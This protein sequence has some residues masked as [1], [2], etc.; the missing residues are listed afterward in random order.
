MMLTLKNAIQSLLAKN[1][2]TALTDAFY[3]DLDFGTGGL[4]GIMGVGSNRV[5]KYTIGGATQGFSNYLL[6]TYP[7]QQVKVAIAHDSRNDSDTLARIT[8]E[9]FAANGIYVYF[10]KELRPTPM[11]SFAIRALGCQ[12]GCYADGF[13]Q[14][15]R[16]QWL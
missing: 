4:R 15:K 11:L 1:D 16:I 12:G 13:P 9:V 2:I 14:S 3:Q 7:N 6:K 8:A 5:N 10:F